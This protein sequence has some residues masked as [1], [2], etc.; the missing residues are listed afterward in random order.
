MSTNIFIN[1]LKDQAEA[2]SKNLRSTGRS[3][4]QARR[5]FRFR[6][7]KVTV[8]CWDGADKKDFLSLVNAES[9]R[10]GKQLPILNIID[11]Q[12]E[13]K[14]EAHEQVIYTHV[15]QEMHTKQVLKD[16]A[17]QFEE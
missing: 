6:D 17:R 16:L 8:V 4:D 10:Q 3:F 7:Q 13:Y 11:R 15:Y 9:V 14:P 12:C 5:I 1:T 2:L